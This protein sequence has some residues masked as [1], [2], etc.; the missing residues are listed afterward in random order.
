MLNVEA[1]F[2]LKT[3]N[4]TKMISVTRKI[5]SH[6]SVIIVLA[7]TCLL[8]IFLTSF[9]PEI[10]IDQKQFDYKSKLTLLHNISVCR[11]NKVIIKLKALNV[12]TV[13]V[14]S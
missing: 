10:V 14:I 3:K 12:I 5:A 4:K 6:K 7:S 1:Y 13:N 9:D 11:R 2:K 8:V